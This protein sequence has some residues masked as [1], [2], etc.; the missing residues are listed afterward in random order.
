MLEDT[1]GRRCGPRQR[2]S[3]EKGT[4]LQI[5]GVVPDNRLCGQDSVPHPGCLLPPPTDRPP[6]LLTSLAKKKPPTAKARWVATAAGALRSE[7]QHAHA[8]R[9]T[10]G[11]IPAITTECS[12]TNL[13]LLSLL[14]CV[15]ADLLVMLLVVA[16]QPHMTQQM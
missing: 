3:R 6:R 15:L 8:T 12:Q 5:S 2:L 4:M 7:R 9:T 14:L 10:N 16:E 1:Q 13:Q 11:S